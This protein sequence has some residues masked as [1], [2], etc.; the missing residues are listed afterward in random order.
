MYTYK[1]SLLRLPRTLLPPSHP[2]RSSQSTGLGSL[3]YTAAPHWLAVLHVVMYICQG[4]Y[5]SLSHPLLPLL[6][7][8]VH[9]LCL[10]L[11]S[12]P[13]AFKYFY[14]TMKTKYNIYIK[15]KNLNTKYYFILRIF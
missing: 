9:Y 4:C 5:P 1:P 2:S 15:Y 7:P 11:D 10:C 6:C 8:Q 14:S 3:C 12:C 13:V